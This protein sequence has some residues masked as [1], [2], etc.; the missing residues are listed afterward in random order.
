MKTLSLTKVIS[1]AAFAVAVMASPLATAGA[2]INT[3]LTPDSI[4]QFQDTNVDRI[5]RAEEGGGI[6]LG[7]VEYRQL[8]GADEIATGDII[9]SIL[10]FTDVNGGPIAANGGVFNAPYGL[11]AYSELVVGAIATSG[12]VDSFNVTANLT[13]GFLA[14]GALVNIYEHTVGLLNTLFSDPPATGIATVTGSPLI[15]SF[16]LNGIDDFWQVKTPDGLLATLF[17]APVG[18]GQQGIY[19]FGITKFSNDGAL[20]IATNGIVSGAPGHVGSFHDV[21][22]DGSAFARSPGTDT[23][24]DLSTNTNVNF[25]TVPEPELLTLLSIGLLAGGLATRRR[26]V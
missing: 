18:S 26:S 25:Q 14:G 10:N 1:A 22:G 8:T 2:L 9:Q 19:E 13:S 21:V 7:A 12:G 17:S 16:G 5:L 24:W 20:P 11:L 4:N 3:L 6:F 23:G 15:A